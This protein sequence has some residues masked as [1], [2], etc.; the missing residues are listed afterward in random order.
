[1]WV[2]LEISISRIIYEDNKITHNYQIDVFVR[3]NPGY[4]GEWRKIGSYTDI[5]RCM[6]DLIKLGENVIEAYKQLLEI[7]SI[8]LAG[9][10]R[11]IGEK[12]DKSDEKEGIYTG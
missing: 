2:K 8:E 6:D 3:N 4:S 10:M 7:D 1:M 12:K 5:H 11:K 9:K